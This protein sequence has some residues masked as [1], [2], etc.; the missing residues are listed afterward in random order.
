MST[1]NPAARSPLFDFAADMVR[2]HARML[3]SGIADSPAR[4]APPSYHGHSF[5]DLSEREQLDLL[6]RLASRSSYW[7]D[8]LAEGLSESDRID[9]LVK[10]A[11]DPGASA[12]DVVRELRE[13]LTGYAEKVAAVRGDELTE[14][15]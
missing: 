11:L 1:N 9:Q 14:L 2:S 13:I 3:Q 12:G 4:T 8:V 15:V 7:R 5:G 10:L 6:G